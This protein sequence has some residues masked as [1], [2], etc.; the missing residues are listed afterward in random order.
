M[1]RMG[2]CDATGQPV[3]HHLEAKFLDVVLRVAASC[4]QQAI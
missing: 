4:S 3:A 1:A 2:A